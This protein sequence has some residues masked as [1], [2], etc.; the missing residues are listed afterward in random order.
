[1]RVAIVGAGMAGLRC[2]E[3]LTAAGHAVTLFDKGRGPG[4]RMATRRMATPLGET[5]FDHGTLW[6]GGGGPDF[7]A[8]ISDWT[9]SGVV[10]NWPASESA[11][12]AFVGMP[13]MNAP[14][15]AMA[16]GL[17]VRFGDAVTGLAAM[18]DGWRVSLD[19]DGFEAVVVAVPPEQAAALLAPVS[20]DFAARAA[21]VRSLPC[22]TVMAAFARRLAGPDI[23]EGG[24]IIERA[25][26][27]SAKPGRTGPEAWVIQATPD[28]S[29]A[30]L[31]DSPAAVTAALLEALAVDLPVVLDTSAHR[32]RYARLDGTGT[33]AGEGALWDPALRLGVCGDWLLGP[34]VASAWTSGDRLAA[35]MTVA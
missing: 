8:Q 30:H 22:W 18:A 33:E 26:R 16:C 7:A 12:D 32:W 25:V 35:M 20:A 29:M 17:D 34:N 13:G 23:V 9:A 4:G 21:S 19:D 31:E 24:T 5:V 14:L 6:F 3:R 15:K 28:W 1:M 2:G 11:G 10:A 27:N